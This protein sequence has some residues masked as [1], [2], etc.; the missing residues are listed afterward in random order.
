MKKEHFEI[1]KAPI[2]LYRFYFLKLDL[3]RKIYISPVVG[4]AAERNGKE[5]KCNDNRPFLT[6]RGPCIVIYSYNVSQRDALFIKS[7]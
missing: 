1:P 3:I 5:K 6:F 2:T 4:L 7:I